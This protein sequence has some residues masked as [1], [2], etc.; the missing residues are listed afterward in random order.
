MTKKKKMR[1]L[2]QSM[3]VLG[4][5]FFMLGSGIGTMAVQAA[6]STETT[7]ISQTEETA[8][9]GGATVS[10]EVKTALEQDVTDLVLC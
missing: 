6:E 5:M 1:K 2:K 4:T 7:E 9:S 8:T 3:V 10:D